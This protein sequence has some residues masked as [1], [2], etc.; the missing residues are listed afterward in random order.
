MTET[1]ITKE[2]NLETKNKVGKNDPDRK[3]QKNNKEKKAVVEISQK[4]N[5]N[6]DRMVL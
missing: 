6:V 5:N 3:L 4:Q 1:I 2:L